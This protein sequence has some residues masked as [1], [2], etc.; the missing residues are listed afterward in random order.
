MGKHTTS[1]KLRAL[2]EKGMVSIMVT[3]I[4]MIV[5]SLIVI[6]F[7]QVSRRSQRESLDRQLSTQAFY[8]AESGINDAREL[9]VTAAENNQAIPAKTSCTDNGGGFYTNLNTNNVLNAGS[10]VSYSCVTVNPAPRQLEYSDVTSNGTIIPIISGTGANYSTITLKW[11][12]KVNTGTPVNGCPTTVNNVFTATGSWNCGYGVMR[13]DLVPVSGAVLA[14][15]SLQDNT[16]TVFAV[17][18]SSGGTTTT[19][20]AGGGRV[21]GTTCNNTECTLTIT[22]L[23]GPEYYLRAISMYQNVS[24]EVNG[25]TNAGTTATFSGAQAI[26]D[27]TG[28]AQDVLRRVQVHL[29]LTINGSRNQLPDNA[30]ESTESICKRFSAMEN[31]FDN[32]PTAPGAGPLCQP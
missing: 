18:L 12:S 29:P 15:G 30:L 31:Y 32:S 26:I 28:K 7:A 10:N 5:M 27:A 6:G 4:L 3:M 23:T 2:N 22:G 9:L 13:L 8:A 25:T 1:Q 14:P 21:V 20:Y 24:L 11:K 17:P 19:T 16:S